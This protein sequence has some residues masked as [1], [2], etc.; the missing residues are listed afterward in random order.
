MT[1]LARR[2]GLP[3]L[4]FYGIGLIVGAGIY[5]VIGAAA[6][7]AG[8]GLWLSFAIGSVIALLTGLSYAELATMHP[9]AGAEFVYLREA[10]PRHRWAAFAVGTVLT[11]AVAATASTVAVAFAGYLGMFVPVPL[12]AAAIGVLT[13]VMLINIA[14]IAP[15]SWINIVFTLIEIAGLLLVISL[16]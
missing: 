2:L 14:G 16:G 7:V 9:E 15:S 5:S 6:G 3:S 13:V 11:I 10:F 8:E 1:K 12:L 4:T